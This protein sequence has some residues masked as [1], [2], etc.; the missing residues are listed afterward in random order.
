LVMESNLRRFTKRCVKLA[1]NVVDDASEPAD[2]RGGGGFAEWTMVSLHCLRLHTEK[3]YRTSIDYLKEMPRITG[4]I[5][6][7]STDLPHYTTFCDWFGKIEIRVIRIFLRLSSP[8]E[9]ERRVA[10]D[11][12]GFDRDRASRHYCQRANYRVR[13]LK[14]TILVDVDTLHVVDVHCTTTKKHDTKIGEQVIKR[15]VKKLLSVSG[16]KGYDWK[17][18]RDELRSRG[19]R[20]LIKHREFTHLDKA[21]NSRMN[22]EDYNQ[23]W[24]SETAFSSIK[25]TLDDGVRS[26]LWHREF[27]EIILKAAV[28]NIKNS[29]KS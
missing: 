27:R 21:H 7:G 25:R 4:E 14:V 28:Y 5:G 2:P 16:D 8:D 18:L 3:S 9:N 20:P 29:T 23:R 26:R 6:L 22:D 10:I 11:S 19:V 13:S 1:K 12:T 15:N 24:M 17:K